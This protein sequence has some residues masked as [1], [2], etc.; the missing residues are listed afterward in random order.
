MKKKHKGSGIV[1][2]VWCIP[3]IVIISVVILAPYVPAINKTKAEVIY[4]K[5]IFSMV[6]EGC[7]RNTEKQKLIKELQDKGFKNINI[8][9]NEDKVEWGEEVRLKIQFDMPITKYKSF[10]EGFVETY[11][12]ITID[13][14]TIGLS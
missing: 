1:E 2:F 10:T 4:R 3:L 14:E 13:K 7:L 6:K 11:E 9:A 5:Y 12:T 8:Q